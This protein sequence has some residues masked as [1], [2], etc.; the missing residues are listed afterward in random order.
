MRLRRQ[1]CDD[2]F[3]RLFT[4]N[5]TPASTP[6]TPLRRR[7]RGQ[8]D[9]T[10]SRSSIAHVPDD[11]LHRRPSAIARSTYYA[12]RLVRLAAGAG[13]R[14]AETEIMAVWK[15]KLAVTGARKT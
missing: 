5:A 4:M 9:I 12:P 10:A 7:C 11:R 15:E 8:F 2:V 1:L 3:H 6:R 14:P 13:R